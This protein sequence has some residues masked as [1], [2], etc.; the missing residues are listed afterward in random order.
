MPDADDF[1][2]EYF[3]NL[4]KGTSPKDGAAPRAEPSL[5]AAK[6]KAR[7]A[8]KPAVAPAKTK[9]ATSSTKTRSG[10]KRNRK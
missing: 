8:P 1:D 5:P 10:K 3:R 2:V 9:P 6:K 7:S 4:L